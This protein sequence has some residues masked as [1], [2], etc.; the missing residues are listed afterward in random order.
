MASGEL[1]PVLNFLNASGVL[2]PLN[3]QSAEKQQEDLVAGRDLQLRLT[4]QGTWLDK[5]A[6]R[7]V[8]SSEPA[9][10]AT[11]SLTPIQLGVGVSGGVEMKCAA[12]RTVHARGMVC[13][14]SD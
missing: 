14:G 13:P 11:A 9:Q 5:A 2:T 4:S 1:P 6:G 7:A 12:V 10:R 8:I 3:K